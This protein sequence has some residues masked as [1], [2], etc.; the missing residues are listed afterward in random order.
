MVKFFLSL[1]SYPWNLVLQIL[2]QKIKFI[3][4]SPWIWVGHLTCSCQW[5][6]NKYDTKWDLK[7]SCLLKLTLLLLMNSETIMQ[8]S[9]SQPAGGWEAMWS[10]SGQQSVYHSQLTRHVITMRQAEVN[11]AS[12]DWK[13]CSANPDCC[14]Q[15]LNFGISK[16][17]KYTLLQL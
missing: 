4:P 16:S 7:R 14:F 3:S 8:M 2:P 12:S 10:H 1:H 13:N 17:N 11:R 15:L 5:N 6:I 9:P